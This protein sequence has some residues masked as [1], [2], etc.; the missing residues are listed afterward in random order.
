[1]SVDPK[2]FPSWV[3]KL[4]KSGVARPKTLLALDPGETTGYALFKYD[5]M[6]EAGQLATHNVYAGVDLLEE[7]LKKHQP[8]MV[9]YEDY[10]VYAWKAQSHSWETLHTPRFIGAIQTLT[11]L[12]QI[13]VLAQMAQ[14][15]KMFCTDQKLQ[16]WD[17]YQ[18]GQR[19]ARDAI[20]HGCYYLLFNN[21]KVHDK[22]SLNL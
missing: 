20:R 5:H 4:D 11:Y 2:S 14:Q 19:H 9:V 21:G 15:A 1:M 12:R 10:R 3:T 17:Y 7:M 16:Q 13:P 18:K 6:V 8:D 22:D